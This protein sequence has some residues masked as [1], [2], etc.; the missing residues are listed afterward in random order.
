ML[1]RVVSLAQAGDFEG[2][3]S[4]GDG[5]CR[6]SLETAGR[7]AVPPDPPTVVGT[8]NIPTTTTAGD[9]THLGGVVLILC[10]IDANGN[11]Y[12]SE[13]LVSTAAMDC[14]SSTPSTGAP[15]G[16]P[17]V[18]TQCRPR[19]SRRLPADLRRR[20]PCPPSV[21]SRHG[22]GS[23][24]ERPKQGTLDLCHHLR[25]D[26]PCRVCGIRSGLPARARGQG[27][28]V[29]GIPFTTLTLA[30]GVFGVLVGLAWMWRIYRAPT[31]VEGAHWRFH[32]D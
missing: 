5:K 13:M 6:R 19:R 20:H 15:R 3:C 12:D 26:C 32:D 7:D 21:G 22:L 14:R 31:K 16:L 11:H 29:L 17:T 28:G 25:R 2:I 4:L 1:D 24:R 18:P 30:V 27:P 10:G 23:D 9:Q 8:R